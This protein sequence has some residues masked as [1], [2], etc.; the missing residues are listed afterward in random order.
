MPVY[1]LTGIGLLDDGSPFCTRSLFWLSLPRRLWVVL[2]LSLE[3]AVL[4]FS[5]LV[6][7][8]SRHLW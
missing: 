6:A 3:M 4:V 2:V 1:F 8:R 5:N 7:C